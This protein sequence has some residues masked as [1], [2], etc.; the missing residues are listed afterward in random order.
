MNVVIIPT[1]TWRCHLPRKSCTYDLML[2]ARML[3]GEKKKLAVTYF[4][5]EKLVLRG[6]NQ[7]EEINNRDEITSQ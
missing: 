1:D 3:T 4:Y 7:L 6:K 5:I 2:F